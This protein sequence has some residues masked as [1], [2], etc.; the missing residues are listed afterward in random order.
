MRIQ[1]VVV[2]E[3]YIVAEHLVVQIGEFFD[4]KSQVSIRYITGR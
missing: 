3:L 2:Q 4:T 1:D